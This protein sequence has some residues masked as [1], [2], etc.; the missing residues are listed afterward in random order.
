MT[1]AVTFRQRQM[2]RIAS[3]GGAEG[4]H[5]ATP[6]DKRTVRVLEKRGYVTIRK[7]SPMTRTGG[8]TDWYV[9][10]TESGAAT[11]AAHDA[12]STR[13]SR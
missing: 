11:L 8:H 7:P 4:A 5:V 3:Y 1:Y 6:E 13:A 10:L 12:T 2:L 9:N